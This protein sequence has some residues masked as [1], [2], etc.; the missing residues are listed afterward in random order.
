MKKIKRKLLPKLLISRTLAFN[1]YLIYLNIFK[2]PTFSANNHTNMDI[3][4]S[5]SNSTHLCIINA[6]S[7]CN[8]TAILEDYILEHNLD[9]IALME[10]W[11]S[12]SEKHKKTIGELTLPGYEFFHVPRPNRGGGGVGIIHKD[13]ISRAYS[14]QYQ[15][16]SFESLVI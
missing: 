13:S 16:S 10:T 2:E 1:K 6:Q 8:K 12:N 3:Y 15:A 4:N 11:L 5:N 9:I 14:S 7:V